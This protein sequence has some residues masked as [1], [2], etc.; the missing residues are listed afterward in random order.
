MNRED[1]ESRGLIRAMEF[2]LKHDARMTDADRVV[3][4]RWLAEP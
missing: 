1:V 4:Q 2:H 3:L